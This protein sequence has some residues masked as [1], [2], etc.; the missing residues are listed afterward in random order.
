MDYSVAFPGLG[1][2][3]S[4]NQPYFSIFGFNIYYY[5]VI[6]T[7]GLL[8]GLVYVFK[9]FRKVGVDPDKAIDC[10]LGGIVGG[11]VGARLYYVIFTWDEFGLEFSSWDAFLASFLRLFNTREGGMAIYGGIIGALLIGVLIARWRKI[12]V[13]ALLDV[14][15][16]GFLIGQGV[17]RWGNFVN[18]EAFGNNTTLPWGMTSPVITN[19]LMSKQDYFSSVGIKVD[20]TLP[21]HPC[22]LY[23]SLWCLLGFV[24]IALYMK[25]RKFDGEAF[26]MYLAYYGAGR[27]VIEGFRTDSLMI[28]ALRVS[29]ILAALLVVASVITI[30]V[31]RSRIKSSHDPNFMPIFAT[32]EEGLR[33]VNKVPEETIDEALPDENT[34]VTEIS[35]ILDETEEDITEED[36]TDVS[37]EAS[38]EADGDGE[39]D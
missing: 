27:M 4:L 9:N 12:N 22:F 39:T 26:L 6:I 32:T 36:N 23:E 7:I 35:E 25:H 11:I 29:Q 3:F 24:L 10:I 37:E 31:V 30:L 38:E 13:K 20:P 33:I 8:L 19:Y 5:G 28:G 18:I 15:G 34:E 17:G 21:V 2:E 14:A 1:L 16:V